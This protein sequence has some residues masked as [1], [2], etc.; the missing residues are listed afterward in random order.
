MSTATM[1]VREAKHYKPEIP[2]DWCPGCGDY[3]VLTVLQRAVAELSIPNEKLMVVSGI[4]CSSNL[5]GFFKSYGMHSLHGRS[6]PV[7]T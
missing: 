1:P 4:G 3:G 7:A 2:P 6:L 5:P